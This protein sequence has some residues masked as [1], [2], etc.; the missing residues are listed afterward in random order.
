M[1]LESRKLTRKERAGTKYKYV[2]TKKYRHK[3]DLGNKDLFIWGRNDKLYVFYWAE[4]KTLFIYPGYKWDGSS[5]V[6]DF[7]SCRRSSCVHDAL[8]QLM[9]AGALPILYR[10]YSDKLYRDISIED[11]MWRWHASVRYWGIKNFAEKHAKVAA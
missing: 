7:L 9:R 10:D 11:G 1:K 3:C 5:G 4:A 8:Y 6:I 2:V